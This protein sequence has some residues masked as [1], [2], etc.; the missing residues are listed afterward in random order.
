MCWEWDE[1]DD[2][3]YRTSNSDE[4]ALILNGKRYDN[5]EAYEKEYGFEIVD[6]GDERLIDEYETE[7]E[8]LDGFEE[9]IKREIEYQKESS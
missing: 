8:A 3:H 7:D 4:G 6:W 5:P 2:T 9:A 1:D